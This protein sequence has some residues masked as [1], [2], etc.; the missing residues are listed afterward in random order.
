[1]FGGT[2]RSA[3][4]PYLKQNGGAQYGIADGDVV[5]ATAV[6]NVITAYINGVQVAQATDT[7]FT[8]G[9]PGIGFYLQGATGVNTDYGFTSFTAS[10]KVP[11]PSAPTELR[12]SV[13]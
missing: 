4:L 2:D 9:S 7:T 8:H 6:G 1:L 13:Q 10:D 5:K 3:N 12:A 11:V